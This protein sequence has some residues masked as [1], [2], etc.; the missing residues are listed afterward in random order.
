LLLTQSPSN[1]ELCCV[2]EHVKEL[3]ELA[4]RRLLAANP[5]VIA[6]RLI[7][8][9]VPALRDPAASARKDLEE[10]MWDHVLRDGKKRGSR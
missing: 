1:K 10:R 4:A 6:Q 2:V 8:R 7:Y 9:H 5:D 3:R